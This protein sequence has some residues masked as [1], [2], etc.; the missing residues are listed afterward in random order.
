MTRRYIHY[1]AA[2]EDYVISRGWPYVPVL[3]QRRVIFSGARVKSFDLMVYPN[4][5]RFRDTDAIRPHDATQ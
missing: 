3:E 2:F 1:E 5:G 4:R